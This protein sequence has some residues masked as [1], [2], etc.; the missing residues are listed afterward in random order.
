MN[1]DVIII[2]PNS[3]ERQ[4]QYEAAFEEIFGKPMTKDEEREWDWIERNRARK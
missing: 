3:S 4:K 1:D 2:N